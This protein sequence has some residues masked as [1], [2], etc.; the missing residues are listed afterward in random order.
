MLLPPYRVKVISIP[1]GQLR[2][3]HQ[4]G[5]LTL[6]AQPV[7]HFTQPSSHLAGRGRG[8]G[9]RTGEQE[10]AWSNEGVVGCWV[11][12]PLWVADKRASKYSSSCGTGGE[13]PGESSSCGT[14]GEGPGDSSSIAGP[15]AA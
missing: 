5:L 6:V 11:H 4:P 8:Q 15:P 9:V 14:G 7:H 3:G 2:E 13:G 12:E 1:F 10:V